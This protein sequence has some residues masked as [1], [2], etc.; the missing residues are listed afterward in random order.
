MA[1]GKK[2]VEETE[3]EGALITPERFVTKLRDFLGKLKEGDPIPI[4]ELRAMLDSVILPGGGMSYN[5]VLKAIVERVDE[6][7]AAN[8]SGQ[9]IAPA[10]VWRDIA[11]RYGGVAMPVFEKAVD[12]LTQ[13]GAITFIESGATGTLYPAGYT[14]DEK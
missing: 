1:R 14:P 10:N 5:N 8:P 11:R 3:A 6:Y 2:F 12:E 7:A 13:D 9:G 4:P